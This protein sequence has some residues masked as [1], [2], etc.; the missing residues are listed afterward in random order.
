M[1]NVELSRAVTVAN[2]D[3]KRCLRDLNTEVFSE[4]DCLLNWELYLKCS[5]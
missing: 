4:S 1:V 3:F 5:T 2:L